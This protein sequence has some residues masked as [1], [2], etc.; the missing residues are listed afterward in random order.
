M[1]SLVLTINVV[2]FEVISERN[3]RL[4]SHL[5]STLWELVDVL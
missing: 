5:L 1:F 3:G 4:I 2:D